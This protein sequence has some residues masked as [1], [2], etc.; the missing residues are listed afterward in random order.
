MSASLVVLTLLGGIHPEN[1]VASSFLQ[2]MQ[3]LEAQHKS[4]LAAKVD[5]PL[6]V[7]R[8]R[9]SGGLIAMAAEMARSMQHL[10][11]VCYV[12]EAQ[13]AALQVVLPA[14]GT[15]VVAKDS[16]LGWH[17]GAMCLGK[18]L[19]DGQDFMR[20]LRESLSASLYM[21]RIVEAGLGSA[22]EESCKPLRRVWP[23]ISKAPCPVLHMF[24][25]TMMSAKEFKAAFPRT[26]KIVVVETVDV[27]PYPKSDGPGEHVCQ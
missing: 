9:S 26:S 14:C 10:K 22:S 1:P 13:S 25:E 19:Y 18:D 20:G 8:I 11:P 15:I 17:S 23:E 4:A 24:Q 27:P 21:S 6:V 16:T 5:M 2:A 12:A 7:V 3:A